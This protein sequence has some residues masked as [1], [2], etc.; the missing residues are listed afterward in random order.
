VA[1]MNWNKV[2]PR[3]AS[4]ESKRQLDLK[5]KRK[6]EISAT[7]KQLSFMRIL[8]IEFP[9]KITKVDASF[10]ISKTLKENDKAKRLNETMDNEVKNICRY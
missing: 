2:K 9:D 10:L 4:F 3:H 6:S 5:L 7:E 1:K 8:K